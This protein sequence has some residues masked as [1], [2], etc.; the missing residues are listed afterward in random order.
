MSECWWCCYTLQVRAV[1][2]GQFLSMRAHT[3]RIGMPCPPERILVTG[4]GSTNPHLLTLMASIFGCP[5][6]TAQRP[7]RSQLKLQREV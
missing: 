7:G 6:Y 4:G 2:E 3:E 1:V 5:V